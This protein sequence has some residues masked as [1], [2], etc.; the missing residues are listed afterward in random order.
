MHR[1]MCVSNRQC[2]NNYINYIY[3]VGFAT[4]KPVR[5]PIG[6]NPYIFQSP[7]TRLKFRISG[8]FN[9]QATFAQKY[10]SKNSKIVYLKCSNLKKFPHA[11]Y[12]LK[13]PKRSSALT[14]DS[15]LKKAS[16]MILLARAHK[17][18]R[19]KL[20]VLRRSFRK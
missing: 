2:L 11:V 17:A 4:A 13:D 12:G 9:Y 18:S 6:F 15:A 16:W 7:H 10:Y 3:Q 14:W 1:K 8:W 20:T 5:N 19:W